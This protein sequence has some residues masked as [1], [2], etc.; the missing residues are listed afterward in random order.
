MIR[1]LI[2]AIFFTFPSLALAVDLEGFY[3]TAKGGISKSIDTGVMNLVQ[4]PDSYDYSDEDIATGSA[5]GLSVGISR[6]KMGKKVYY[7]GYF[8]SPA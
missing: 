6:N 8:Y 5:F 1:K 7:H 4:E 2:L 3:I